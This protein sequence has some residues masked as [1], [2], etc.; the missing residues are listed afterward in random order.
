MAAGRWSMGRDPSPFR[1][2]REFEEMR[3]RFDED[4]VRPVMH[5]VWERIPEDLKTWSPALDVFE[6]G[7]SLI[8]KVELPGMKQEDVDVSITENTVIIKG[9]RK[10]ETGV[11]EEEYFRNE[12][13]YGNFYRSLDLPISVDTNNIE[14]IYEDGILRISLQRTAGSKP[15]KVAIEV[16]KST[17]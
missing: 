12:V 2:I 16:K 5:A 7:E 10:P 4:I 3:R 14:A 15:K 11:K 9:E 13:A 1:P 8:V 6:K 17:N